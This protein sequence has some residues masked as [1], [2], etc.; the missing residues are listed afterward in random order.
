MSRISSQDA[1]MKRVGLRSE[2]QMVAFLSRKV[3]KIG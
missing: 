1:N 2:G 3:H